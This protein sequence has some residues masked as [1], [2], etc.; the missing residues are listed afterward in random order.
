MAS[1]GLPI[2]GDSLYPNVIDVARDDFDDPLRLLAQRV[3]FD[4]PISGCLR[5]FV[6]GRSIDG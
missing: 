3:E 6:S 2:T 4:D 5:R 1:L